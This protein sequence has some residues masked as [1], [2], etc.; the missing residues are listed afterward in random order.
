MDR[1]ETIAPQTALWAVVV[2]VQPEGEHLALTNQQ[3]RRDDV[4]WGYKVLCTY[5]VVWAP[6][7][8]VLTPLRGFPENVHIEVTFVISSWHEYF[9]VLERFV[10]Q[11][12]VIALGLSTASECAEADQ[13][14]IH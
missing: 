5:F 11:L 12:V 8:P 9:R 13:S 1:V 14:E 2:E 7:S 6:A 3:S 10:A 4:F